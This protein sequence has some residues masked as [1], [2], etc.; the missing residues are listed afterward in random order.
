MLDASLMPLLAAA[1]GAV[2]FGAIV[3]VLASPYFTGE[4]QAARRIQD[5]T[6]SKAGR[7]IRRAGSEQLNNRK[8]AVAD[9]LKEL[10]VRQKQSEKVSLRLRLERAGLEIEPQAFWIASAVVGAVTGLL[11][12]LSIPNI[13]P[14]ACVAVAFVGAFGIPRWIVAF[15]TKTRQ[16]KFLEEFANAI[17]VI[18]RG[19]KSGLP[20]NECLNIIA[21]ESPEPIRTEFKQVVEQQRV[22]VP[23][24]DCFDKMMTRL[25]LSEVKFFAIV[26]GIQQ[27]AGGNLSEAAKVQALSAEAKASAGVLAALPFAVMILVYLSTP[28]YIVLLWTTKMGQFMLLCSAVWMTMGVLVMRKMINFKF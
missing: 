28:A 12:Y 20:L 5:I 18:V 2:A 6:E 25:P 11:T 27:S 19:I 14:I 9:T 26:V 8:K 3:F 16:K 7:G 13:E 22:G 10:E 17:D 4:K 21:R 15:M 23:L 1:L 24:Q